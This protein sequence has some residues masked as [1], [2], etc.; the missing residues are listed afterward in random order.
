[1]KD[2]YAGNDN[3]LASAMNVVN[4]GDGMRIIQMPVSA[5]TVSG[6]LLCVHRTA[7]GEDGTDRW[8][9][10]DDGKLYWQEGDDERT[11]FSGTETYT[12]ITD[13][14]Y[15]GR[16]IL[17]NDG[18]D[19]H[20][21]L[22]KPSVSGY[23]YLGTHL[24]DVRVSF[25]MDDTQ[26]LAKADK[27]TRLLSL[28]GLINNGDGYTTIT[29][30]DGETQVQVY[31]P[32]IVSDKVQDFK[33]ACAGLAMSGWNDVQKKKGFMFPF[34]ATWAIRLYDNTHVMQGCPVL[35]FP[36]VRRNGCFHTVDSDGDPIDAT[37][38]QNIRKRF[39]YT[40]YYSLLKYTIFADM[41][42]LEKW[43]DIIKGVDIF[44]SDDVKNYKV[45]GNW[46]IPA[47]K[48]Y[49]TFYD[50]YY[51][52]NGLGQGVDV[53]YLGDSAVYKYESG[54]GFIHLMAS[55]PA[56]LLPEQK[57]DQE[58]IDE[59]KE[60][61][62]FYKIFGVERDEIDNGT[63]KNCADK[64]TDTVLKTLDTQERLENDYFGRTKITGKWIDTYNSRVHAQDITRGFFDGFQQFTYMATAEG[65]YAYR[66]DWDVY[67][68][69]ET[70]SGMRVVKK[71]FTGHRN[72]LMWFY[73]PDPRARRVW[74]VY[75][76]GSHVYRIN[77]KEHSQLNGS[78]VIEMLPSTGD[79]EPTDR[80]I[81]GVT[82]P[83]VSNAPERLWNHVMVSEAGNPFVWRAKGDISV[84]SKEV[85][86]VAMN[87]TAL[88]ELEFGLHQLLV[89]TMEG[90]WALKTNDEGLYNAAHPVSR[91]VCEWH[92]TIVETDAA[93]YFGTRKG[94]MRII[95]NDIVC[96]SKKMSD[97]FWQVV[98]Q[99]KIAYDYKEGKLWLCKEGDDECFIYDM[100]SQTWW[101]RKLPGDF[102]TIAN[103]Y[104]D[105]LIQVAPAA[106]ET[107]EVSEEEEETVVTP[108]SVLSLTGRP[109]QDDDTNTYSGSWETRPLKFGTLFQMKSIRQV[110][111]LLSGSGL[112][113][114]LW[115]SDDMSNWRQLTST[116]GKGWKYYK[117]RFTWSNT[118]ASK[119]LSATAI[120]VQTR[121]GDLKL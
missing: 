116:R 71:S 110:R 52:F 90:V 12:E 84:G 24:P 54:N 75:T 107:Q 73:Y 70:D 25:R 76:S 47:I 36:S 29:L 112:S 69:I 46:K 49:G 28:D 18:T 26:V 117:M 20:Y 37:E 9:T 98:S 79:P 3:D 67:V 27:G 13:I 59:L 95:G 114:Q 55:A 16:T 19:V 115:G 56:I 4:D 89:F 101:K 48:G 78:Y 103:S 6:K 83:S 43:K 113:M 7:D 121:R 96:V 39:S 93:V 74:F 41:T 81:T 5:G 17:V 40:P 30:E 53:G 10:L 63:E 80:M 99:S 42:E 97:G 60:R 68:E 32:D 109:K 91:E 35:M 62:I 38:S 58:I 64:M 50:V 94:L 66:Y 65:D 102:E 57:T 120:Q 21:Y 72:P 111:H 108:S 104:P 34:F 61:G 11:Q 31:K 2:M 92:H 85:V 105:T 100:S 44:V 106:A 77:A 86:G 8:I 119:R 87:V 15:V 45:D 1:M 118:T 23:I 88:P 51:T 33:D 82:P 22:W 14:T